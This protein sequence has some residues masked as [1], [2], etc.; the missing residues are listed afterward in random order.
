MA[1]VTEDQVEL[2]SIEWFKELGY[3]YVCGYDI[4]PDGETP[5]RSD[6]ISVVLKERL[7]SALT[8]INPDIP[9]SAIATALSQL[10]SPNIPA[11]MSAN[12]QVVPMT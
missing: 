10:V 5:E 8:R 4:A 12:R 7:L 9:Q 1:L 2:Q 3:Q 6:Y 11:L